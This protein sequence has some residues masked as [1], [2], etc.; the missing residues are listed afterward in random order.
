M[1]TLS[2]CLLALLPLLGLA[3]QAP[4]AYQLSTYILDIGQGK[5]TPGV[6]VRLEK[7][8][9]AKRTWT[10]VAEKQ[11]DAASRIGDFLPTAGQKTP[12]TR[13]YKFIFLTRPYFA[14]R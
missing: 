11:T 12:A 14:A 3:Q 2:F 8:D 4:P 13:T 10:P 5:P 7:Y 6:M 1:K 9:D